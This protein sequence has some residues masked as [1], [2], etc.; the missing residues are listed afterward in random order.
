MTNQPTPPR[1]DRGGKL[2][3]G[4]TPINPSTAEPIIRWKTDPGEKLDPARFE[5]VDLWNEPVAPIQQIIDAVRLSEAAAQYDQDPKPTPQ[6]DKETPMSTKHVVTFEA[7]NSDHFVGTCGGCDWK[8]ESNKI[9]EVNRRGRA[10]ERYWTTP[11]E[12]RNQPESGDQTDQQRSEPID[13]YT[14]VEVL[15][16][17]PD[18]VHPEDQQLV[19]QNQVMINGTPV[20]VAKDGIFIDYGT[21]A[22]PGPPGNVVRVSLDLLI[23]EFRIRRVPSTYGEPGRPRFEVREDGGLHFEVTSG[24]IDPETQDRFDRMRKKRNQQRDKYKDR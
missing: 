14:L 17:L 4:L 18:G 5:L 3:A 21:D 9:G 23:D 1:R 22:E 11:P 16:V 6:Q 19:K 13:D 12:W 2:P 24:E 8:F 15:E 7:L 10:H 20:R